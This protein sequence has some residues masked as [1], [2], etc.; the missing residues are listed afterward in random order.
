LPNILPNVKHEEE[1]VAIGIARVGEKPE[2]HE[3]PAEVDKSQYRERDFLQLASRAVSN[4]RHQQDQRDYEHGRC[5][6][7][8]V[9][10]GTTEARVGHQGHRTES[11]DREIHDPRHPP[12]LVQS[13]CARKLL[14]S[15]GGQ[16]G[17]A[18]NRR[19]PAEEQRAQHDRN[20]DEP[21][22]VSAQR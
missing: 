11:K 16:Q 20:H 7:E 17:D 12:V 1:Q 15:D 3:H 18:E 4:D 22:T 21:A 19:L 2:M 6:E 10:A 13:R 14:E 8:P 9:P 5:H